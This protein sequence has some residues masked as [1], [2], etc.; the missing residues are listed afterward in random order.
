MARMIDRTGKKYNKWTFIKFV[1]KNKLGKPVWLCRCD[2]GTEKIITGENV[3]GGYS[4]Q[5]YECS[6]IKNY[7]ENS[8]P[9]PV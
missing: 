1:G 6:Y 8:I 5:C 4:K 9:T 3:V 2:C 7:K